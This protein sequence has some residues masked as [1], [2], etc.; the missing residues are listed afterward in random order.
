MNTISH[1]SVRLRRGR[2]QARAAIDGVRYT[3]TFA[4]EQ[5]A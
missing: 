3:K 1:G 2:Y 4:N 5:E